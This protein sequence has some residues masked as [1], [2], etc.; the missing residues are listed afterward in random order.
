MGVLPARV[1]PRCIVQ[2][3]NSH[4][5]PHMPLTAP[6]EET[7]GRRARAKKLFLALVFCPFFLFLVLVFRRRLFL[8]RLESLEW[9]GVRREEHGSNANI[10]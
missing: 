6:A 7:F 4:L 2:K 5:V 10:G 1:P 9:L 3:F 8:I